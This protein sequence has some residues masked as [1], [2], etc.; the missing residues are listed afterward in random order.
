MPVFRISLVEMFVATQGETTPVPFLEI[1]SYMFSDVFPEGMRRHSLL[2][3]LR[4]WIENI[5]LNF[6]PHIF[7]SERA[8]IE[9]EPD[10]NV[11]EFRA[12]RKATFQSRLVIEGEEISELDRDEIVK[13]FMKKEDWEKK[14]LF[15][16]DNPYFYVAFYN[17]HGRIKQEY[18]DSEIKRSMKSSLLI[19]QQREVLFRKSRGLVEEITQKNVQLESTISELQK[20]LKKFRGK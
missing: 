15:N 8:D 3:L 19:R 2:N 1:R 18:G 20:T 16:R 14:I 11:D 12:I 6:L 4:G 7:E 5:K 17:K 13:G 10:D 9:S